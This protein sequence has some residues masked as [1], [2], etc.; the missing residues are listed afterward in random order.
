MENMLLFLV[1]T[2]LL[3]SSLNLGIVVDW[4]HLIVLKYCEMFSKLHHYAG[5]NPVAIFF[6]A[7]SSINLQEIE[8]LFNQFLKKR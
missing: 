1:F 2:H 4:T 5:V 8:P 3:R 6:Y 7:H